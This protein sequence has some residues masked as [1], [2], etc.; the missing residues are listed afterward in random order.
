MTG[1]ALAVFAIL[2]IT[3]ALFLSDRLRLD[4]VALM[5]L[6]SLTLTGLITSA[7]AMAGFSDPVVL[8]VAGLF[9]VGEGLQQTG[10]AR[11]LG[12]WLTRVGGKSEARQIAVMMPLVA[13][14]SALMSSTGTVAVFLPVVISVAW[15]LGISPSRL[16]LPLATASLLGGMLTL[17]GTP[18]NL[19]VSNELVSQG[20]P[21]F[22]F[23][24]FTPLGLVA[25]GAGVGFMAL[26]GRAVLPADD[27]SRPG[28]RLEAPSS[29]P[30]I[31]LTADYQLPGSLFR[32]RVRRNSPLAQRTVGEARIRSRYGVNVLT[33][34]RDDEKKGKTRHFESVGPD[35]VLK[36][37]DRLLVQGESQE[38]SRMVQEENLAVVPVI[39]SR[40]EL[41]S[42]E[43]GMAEALLTPRSR[44]IGKT[45]EGSRFRDRYGVNVISMRRMGE[46]LIKDQELSALPLRFGDTLLVQGEWRRIELL[47]EEKGDFVVVGLPQQFMEKELPL[48][49]AGRALTV[50]SAML[51]LLTFGLLPVETSVLLAA[52]AMVLAGCLR[53]EDAYHSINW[54]S[55]VLIAGMLPMATA[56]QKTGGIG[57][58]A[59]SLV[60]LVGGLGPVA[61]LSGIFLLTS[62]FSQF[63]SNTATTVLLAPIAFQSAV[64][65]NVAPEPLLMAVAVAAST[66][67]ATPIASPVNTLVL[68]PGGYRFV[69]FV[70]V[71]V[72]LQMIVWIV[73]LIL[74]PLLFPF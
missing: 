52:V 34:D 23:F 63:V 50:V 30:A 21:P 22:G 48:K 37:S 8:A 7:E 4:L 74:L 20:L 49:R 24:A 65:M 44:L 19:I 60:A 54:Q 29:L 12:Q 56:L 18:P 61:L 51:V 69:D 53:M 70:K 31:D 2:G 67:F 71:G 36:P 58:V 47:R 72:P 66:S 28:G 45:L 64:Q 15:T 55:L 46:R 16:L 10:V 73:S 17:I 14:L 3:V 57:F 1:E 13:M 9:V 62:L 6:L 40:G 32:L 26:V 41:F 59:D 11:R 42:E 33:L 27:R 35:M 43:L 38:V 39:E 5:A 68:G 25:L